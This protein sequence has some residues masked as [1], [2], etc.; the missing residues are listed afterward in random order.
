MEVRMDIQNKVQ[1]YKKQVG[2]RRTPQ[3]PQRANTKLSITR[4]FFELQTADFAWK[5][6]WD[7]KPN[8]KVQ[9]YKKYKTTKQ[10]S[11][12]IQKRKNQYKKA[13]QSKNTKDQKRKKHK[14]VKKHK[15]R[16]KHQ[17]T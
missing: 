8:N 15:K 4:S 17:K 14:N 3:A 13:K 9:K 11:T 2:H 1:K 16:K 7:V 10:K 12:K 6:I 5:F